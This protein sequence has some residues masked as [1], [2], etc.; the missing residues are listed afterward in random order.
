[1][2]IMFNWFKKLFKRKP[3]KKAKTP[4]H[5]IAHKQKRV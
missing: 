2:E 1:M 3:K 4:M 5:I